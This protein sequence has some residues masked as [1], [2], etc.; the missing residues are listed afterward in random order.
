M[1]KKLDQIVIEKELLD[2]VQVYNVPGGWDEQDSAVSD[3]KTTMKERLYLNQNGKC[4]YCGLPLSTRNPEIDHIAP[5]GGK[6]R[7]KHT[8]CTFLPINLVYACRNCNSSE[9]KGQTD[10]VLSKHVSGYRN[11]SFKI[12]HPY[13]DDPN[14][15]FECSEEGTIIL[16]PKKGADEHHR[17]KAIFTLHLFNLQSEQKLTEIAKQVAFERNPCNIQAIVLEISTY[18]P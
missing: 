15:Y 12:V 14:E 3:F 1:L 16:L 9:C 18:K 17:E 11:W 6:K 10:V 5:K 4:A 2:S 13:L 7:P 8:E